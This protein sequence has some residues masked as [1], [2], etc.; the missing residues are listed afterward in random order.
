M[1]II[2]GPL[3]TKNQQEKSIPAGTVWRTGTKWC[4]LP[5]GGLSRLVPD[6]AYGETAGPDRHRSSPLDP[7]VLHEP[8]LDYPCPLRTTVP[9]GDL[10]A[11]AEGHQVGVDNPQFA[12]S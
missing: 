1:T 10:L 9:V 11:Q 2:E 8:L 5:C 7:R 4:E 3:F 6:S 12:G